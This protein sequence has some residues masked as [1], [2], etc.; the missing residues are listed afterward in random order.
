MQG[1]KVRELMPKSAELQL[2]I[3]PE[4]TIEMVRI[5]DA[6]ACVCIDDFLLNPNSMVEYACAHS[7]EFVTVERAY[8]GVV[9]P[10][11]DDGMQAIYQFIRNEMSRLFSFCRGGIDFHTQFSLATLQPEEF[12]LI[13]RLCHSDPRLADDRR[14][15]AALLYLFDDPE[16]GGTGFYRWRDVEFWHEISELLRDDPNAGREILEERFRMFRD[17]PCYMTDSN[18]AAELLDVAPP[19]F[20]RLIFYSGDIPHS[21]FIKHPELLSPDPSVGRLTLNCFASVLPKF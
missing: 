5:S 21:A 12:T 2:R 10:V 20:N 11:A 15:F 7:N 6:V 4:L 9:L 13:Q 17:P 1:V 19:R 16:M 14:N 18:E 8:P 3:N